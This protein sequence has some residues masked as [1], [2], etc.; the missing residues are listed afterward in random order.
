MRKFRI[1]EGPES[2]QGSAEWLQFRKDKIG[3]S[4]APCIMEIDPWRTKLEL[5]E[6]IIF[7]RPKEK[8]AAMQRGND[9]EEEARGWLNEMWNF[10]FQPAVIQSTEYPN[11]I[12]SLDGYFEDQDGNIS[13][14][15]IKVP[16]MEVYN[17]AVD[18]IIPDHYFAQMQ[19]Q[20]MLAGVKQMVYFVYRGGGGAML[21]CKKNDAYCKDLLKKELEFLKSIQD[22]EPPSPSERDW[23]EISDPQLQSKL[24]AYDQLNRQMKSIKDEMDCIKDFLISQADHPR[25]EYGQM[26]M[27]KIQS[28]GAYNYRM[29]VEEMGVALSEK[30]RGKGKEYWTIRCHEMA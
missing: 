20:M 26:K 16:S 19:H 28:K 4:M 2:V 25:L 21:T 1:V 23:K 12:A 17:K 6:E 24:E 7:D 11:L 18:G 9:M 3:A 13:L 5:W 14:A 8:T 10:H 15:E 27:Q 29:Q 30:Y 22:F